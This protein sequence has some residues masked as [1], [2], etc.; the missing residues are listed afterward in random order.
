MATSA[1][2]AAL[3]SAPAVSA[4]SR[5][6]HVALASALINTSYGTMSYSLRF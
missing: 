2:D 6:L 4:R 3:S 5:W 1:P